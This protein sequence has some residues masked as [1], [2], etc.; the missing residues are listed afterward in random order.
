MNKI[1]IYTTIISL[2]SISVFAQEDKKDLGT[3]MINV[4]KAYNPEI[5]DAFKIKYSPED[6]VDEVKKQKLEYKPISTDVA[7]TYTPSKIGAKSQPRK[8]R[9][10]NALDNFFILG[11]GNYK[12]PLV[13]LYM[14][15]EKVKEHRY[16]LHLQHISSEGGIENVR[17]NDAFMSSSIDA[18]YWKQFKDYQLKT[19]IAYSYQSVNWYGVPDA[20][21]T[22]A[23]VDDL[24]TGQYYQTFQ[25]DASYTYNGK[26]DDAIFK[27]SSFTAYRMWDRYDS[28]ENRI[29]AE[30]DFAIPLEGQFI[31]INANIDFMDNYFAQNMDTTGDVINRY[32]NIGVTP[33]FEMIK[34]NVTLNLGLNLVYSAD[35]DGDNSQFRVFPKVEASVNI[36]DN[37]M[38]AYAG[39][40]GELKQNSFQS[41]VEEMPFLSPTMEITPSTVQYDF[42]L[43]LRGKL[44]SSLAY[45]T[46]MSYKKENGFI[47][48]MD[49]KGSTSSNGWESWNSFDAVQ[50]TV[51]VFSFNAGVDFIAMKDLNV[52]ANLNFNSF[53]SQNYDK[54]YNRPDFKISAM[55]DYRFLEDFTVGTAM[56]FVGTRNYLNNPLSTGITEEGQL[57]SYFDL[58]LNAGYDVTKKLGTFLRLNNILSQNYELYKNYKVQGFQVMAGLSYKF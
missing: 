13:E 27:R 22:D 5:S 55:A 17:F 56:Y 9:S 1:L 51:K 21:I 26:K 48:F 52:S 43:G 46:S 29:K 47:Q 15:N 10:K 37:L 16:G 40:G 57:P 7:S 4:V 25:G 11:Y 49:S 2:F 30:G 14:N 36:V 24:N 54:V 58:N 8:G 44:T 28:Y 34:E 6:G 38:I 42:T 32:F 12:T 20:I 39:L 45:N 18:F 50:D 35:L 23:L 53:S 41:V 33:S 31:K 3:E 19:N